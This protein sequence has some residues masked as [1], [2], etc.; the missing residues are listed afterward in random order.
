MTRILVDTNILIY[1][2]H[3][4]EKDKHEQCAKI[5]NGLVDSDGIVL[6][7]QNLVEFSRVLSEKALPSI[8]NELIRQY[9]FD[10]S[11]ASTVISYSEHTIMAALMLSKQHKI[12]FFD[13][14]L[15]A[16]MQENG[17]SKIL[18]ENTKDFKKVKWL[19]AE[20]PFEKKKSK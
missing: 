4:R 8:D 2:H 19:E 20:S 10:L 3:K 7:I 17:I 14:L 9:I 5:V 18:T 1:A 12:H 16:T 11:E 6:S 15:A 13:A